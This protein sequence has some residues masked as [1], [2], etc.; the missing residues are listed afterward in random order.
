[1]PLT[2]NLARAFNDHITAEMAAAYGLFAMSVWLGSQKLPGSASW[3]RIESDSERAHSEEIV[4]FIL[5]RG[6]AVV[7]GNMWTPVSEFESPLALFEHAL[8]SQRQVSTGVEKLYAAGPAG[9]R[10]RKPVSSQPVG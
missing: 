8:A 4:R 1:M 9:P 7:L 3:M 6:G 5:D 2:K 10:H